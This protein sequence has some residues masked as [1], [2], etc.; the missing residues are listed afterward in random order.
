MGGR[1]PHR[2]QGADHLRRRLP[3]DA[4]RELARARGGRP[5]ALRPRR[6]A[7]LLPVLPGPL[8]APGAPRPVGPLRLHQ[9]ADPREKEKALL[10]EV[11]N[12]RLAMLGMFGLI[13]ASKGLIVPG[14]DSLDIPKYA[15]EPMAPFS[16]V[17][18]GLP[19]VSD[20]LN[21]ASPW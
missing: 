1:A 12:G 2:G 6:Q 21:W 11:N 3:R 7:G 18:S 17:N 13:S 4:R 5:E 10:A 15:G 20:M 8:P 19:Y 16:A 9:E 14:L